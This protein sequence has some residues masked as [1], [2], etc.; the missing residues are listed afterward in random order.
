MQVQF[1]HAYELP[2]P[3]RDGYSFF[4]W[5][6][7]NVLVSNSGT[8]IIEGDQ[9]LKAKWTPISYSINYVLNGGTNNQNNPSSYTIEDNITLYNATKKGYTFEGWYDQNNHL[10]TIINGMTGNLTLTAHYN[11][12]NTYNVN[13]DANGGVLDQTSMSVQYDHEYEL[14]TPTRR[15]YNFEGWYEG[16]NKI[17]TN[18]TW[19][20]D[21]DK[22]LK[23]DWSIITYTITYVGADNLTNPNPTT[24]T[25][26]SET[27]TL[28]SLSKKGYIFC[29]WHDEANHDI[30]SIPKGSIGN[31]TLTAYFVSKDCAMTLDAN[32]GECIYISMNFTY[33]ANY[34]IPA[35]TR[36][37]YT[38][39]GWYLGDTLI[40][41][42]GVWTYSETNGTLV[43]HWSKDVYS[44]TYVI[45]DGVSNNPNNPAS[46]QVDSEDITLYPL[47]KTGYTF[48]G[49]YDQN[50]QK[51]ESILTGS[52]GNLTLT[53]VFNDGN[54][55]TV[56][57]DPDGGTFEDT[58][59]SDLREFQVQYDH[60]Y[61]FPIVNK[62]GYTFQYMETTDGTTLSR[63]GTWKNI[64]SKYLSLKY[65]FRMTA[66]TI[67]F[68]F[69]CEGV[70]FTGSELSDIT[71]TYGGY[72]PSTGDFRGEYYISGKTLYTSSSYISKP[73]YNFVGWFIDN[74]PVSEIAP[75]TTGTL[76]I[77]GRFEP[78]T[79]TIYLPGTGYGS[80]TV[81]YGKP[82]TLYPGDDQY[83]EDNTWNIFDYWSLNGQ[84]IP[85][86]GDAWTYST[87]NVTLTANYYMAYEFVYYINSTYGYNDPRNI[88]MVPA[89]D[90][91]T[92][93]PAICTHEGY[94]FDYW[95]DMYNNV[96]TEICVNQ[97]DMY[98]TAH[99][100]Q[101]KFTI[102]LDADGGSVHPS[103]IQVKYGESVDLPTPTR[104]HYTFLGW[105]GDG[106]AFLPDD[107]HIDSWTTTR[108]VFLTALWMNDN[109]S[110][111]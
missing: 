106:L 57:L 29:A 94:E 56:T 12:G 108:D 47:S 10:V 93:Y 81:T 3:T 104:S 34:S 97:P 44:I 48:L 31:R 111:L 73:G 74:Q 49:W 32:G 26:E 39:Q 53:A 41:S 61:T 8:W 46:Y 45:N 62:L 5:F 38:F 14:P 75:G 11:N 37:G 90:T 95:T 2:T 91:I 35:P 99:F 13:F 55:Y 18:G 77:E 52:T 15:G 17:A 100:K 1:D 28:Q 25:V 107:L 59:L 109:I 63:T 4:G 66:Y 42:S 60:A 89:G 20:Y 24:Y 65:H 64:D 98:V 51:V 16:T 22:N 76:H 102:S 43:A 92:L 72:S 33:D 105:S 23:A 82:Y 50:N 85:T 6:I 78:K 30:T 83:I 27:I 19:T 110:H 79:L 40:P 80:K 67:Y 103:T 101:R 70:S 68:D 58:G 84:I 36:L 87:T 86:S 69:T 7:D 54:T 71:S 21:G 96:V 88:A 9:T